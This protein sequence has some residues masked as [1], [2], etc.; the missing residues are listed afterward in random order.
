MR[1]VGG[2][3]F[4]HYAHEALLPSILVVVR[5]RGRVGWVPSRGVGEA[6]LC[7][8]DAGQVECHAQLGDDDVQL[9]EGPDFSP[10]LEGLVAQVGAV[11]EVKDRLFLL[12][13]SAGDLGGIPGQVG[14]GSFMGGALKTFIRRGARA[15]S[16]RCRRFGKANP[17]EKGCEKAT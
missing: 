12:V 6:W 4:V 9:R 2:C 8:W 11:G 15:V 1:V 7:V 14:D 5:R 13:V 3:D 16:A 17:L 10:P